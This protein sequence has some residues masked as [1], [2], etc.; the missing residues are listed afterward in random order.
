M[1][2]NNKTYLDRFPAAAGI[3]G[4]FSAV[5][6]V[7]ENR[8]PISDDNGLLAAFFFHFLIRAGIFLGLALMLQEMKAGLSAIGLA[9]L[10]SAITYFFTKDWKTASS[11]LYM[12]L[13]LVSILMGMLPFVLLVIM[14]GGGWKR[15]KLS[16]I[17]ITLFVV[18]VALDNQSAVMAAQYLFNSST[19]SSVRIIIL[20]I[21]VAFVGGSTAMIA[22]SEL[23]NFVKTDDFIKKTRLLN[24]ANTPSSFGNALAFWVLKLALF[25]YC[26]SLG[27]YARNLPT[28]LN[29]SFMADFRVYFTTFTLCSIAGITAFVLAIAWYLRKQ[30]FEHILMY[31]LSNRIWI[32]LFSLPFA[33]FIAWLIS[34]A[35]GNRQDT[36]RERKSTLE[37][38]ASGSARTVL[39]ITGICY[40]LLFINNFRQAGLAGAIVILLSAGLY[41]LYSIERAGFYILFWLQ[42]LACLIAFYKLLTATEATH[43]SSDV[44]SAGLLFA[45]GAL[46]FAYTML[47][48]PVFH[49]T[50]F[51]Y[52]PAGEETIEKQEGQDLF[53]DY[54]LN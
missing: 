35:L 33:G 14:A 49:P 28:Y 30:M 54:K 39:I 2:N 9:F 10:C 16:V 51:E 46:G 41:F 18:Q 27:V 13:Y 19:E 48:L 8:F 23:M 37:D 52:I 24:L 4:I 25:I 1:T 7:C 6:L 31:N 15:D 20:R 5:A 43:N 45:F 38:Y 34:L 40:L 44:T 50:M 42:V 17:I 21:L 47:Q 29:S 53:A 3:V 32:W 11:S 22:I 12:I 36:V 26:L